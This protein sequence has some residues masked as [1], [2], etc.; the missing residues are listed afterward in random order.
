VQ[1]AR[2]ILLDAVIARSPQ[3]I[4]AEQ[5]PWVLATLDSKVGVLLNRMVLT[6]QG[7]E[8]ALARTSS[9]A[10]VEAL[11]QL[12][13][14]GHPSLAQELGLDPHLRYRVLVADASSSREARKVEALLNTSDGVSGL[15]N[16]CLCRVTSQLPS[17]ERLISVLVVASPPVVVGELPAA[18]TL[19]RQG[20]D[21]GRARGHT[22]LKPATDYALDLAVGGQRMLTRFLIEGL[23]ARLD[24]VD[25]FHRQL[26]ET[27][28][29]FISHGGRLD[30]TAAILHV[31]PNTVS[32]R[33]RRLAD[34][35]G[36]SVAEEDGRSFTRSAHWW[37][38]LD[39]WL[40]E[41][42]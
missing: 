34:L 18:H 23:L 1:A 5:L 31:H 28:H 35:T 37:W 3:L 12:V 25:P 36:F 20:L 6:H 7:A 11:R 10:R 13:D 19:C 41:T 30:V 8:R 40:G 15:V 32:H 17:P 4:A 39:A 9:A 42:R 29:A 27:G 2:A 33:L 24:R 16:G 26:A 22:G 38:A 14:S 21:I